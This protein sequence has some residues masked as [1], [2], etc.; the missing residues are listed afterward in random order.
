MFHMIRFYSGEGKPTLF[1]RNSGG[2]MGK[3]ELSGFEDI[4][5]SERLSCIGYKAPDGYHACKNSAINTRQCPTCIALDVS[6]AY[7]VGDFSGYP[8]LYQQAKAE[9]YALYLAGFGEDILKC[10]ITRKERFLSRMIEQGADFGCIIGVF[11]GPDKIYSAEAE[12]Q[13]RFSFSNS[14]RMAQKMRRL[15]FDKGEAAENFRSSVEMVR[16]SGALPDFTPEILDLSSHYPRMK[17][18]TETDSIL[19]QILG[20]KGEILLFKSE[21]GGEYAVNMR[22]TVGTHF[23]WKKGE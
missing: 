17:A 7:T 6:R 19:G 4:T 10:G 3:I 2:E 23:D 5:F 22:K 16:T 1:C 20:S 21:F 9:E 15:H 13:S 12:M 11:A 8:L 14:V 18:A